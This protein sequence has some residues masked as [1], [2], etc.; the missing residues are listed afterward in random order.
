MSTI[1]KGEQD[2]ARRN[3]GRG[4]KKKKAKKTAT[5]VITNSEAVEE[6]NQCIHTMYLGL[7]MCLFY[8]K[9]SRQDGHANE[10]FLP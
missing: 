6:L 2:G 7:Y 10:Y 4:E 1:V 9:S 5:S 8:G 3:R